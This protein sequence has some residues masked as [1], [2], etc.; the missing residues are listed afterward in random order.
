MP[1]VYMDE[2]V[3]VQTV[4]A[5]GIGLEPP[6]PVEEVDKISA[7][8]KEMYEVQGKANVLPNPQGGTNGEVMQVNN[9]TWDKGEAPS[10][11]VGRETFT[12][13]ASPVFDSDTGILEEYNLDM[14][15][16]DIFAAVDDGKFPQCTVLGKDPY[17]SS[18]EYALPTLIRFSVSPTTGLVDE[19]NIYPVVEDFDLVRGSSALKGFQLKRYDLSIGLLGDES[20]LVLPFSDD[21]SYVNGPNYQVPMVRGSSDCMTMSSVNSAFQIS[22]MM[23]TTLLDVIA[24]AAVAGSITVSSIV[25]ATD[26][27][28]FV[29]SS[30]LLVEDA[31]SMLRYGRNSVIIFEVAGYGEFV[32]E[33]SSVYDGVSFDGVS[34]PRRSITMPLNFDDG[35]VFSEMYSGYLTLGVSYLDDEAI[36]A[37]VVI[38]L[39]KHEITPNT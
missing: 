2:P 38:H 34:T 35:G 4:G 9:D 29:Q 15:V 20:T 11:V 6:V 36:A 27:P 19:M 33:L 12:F 10:P 14:E 16:A 5:G 22:D 32:T 3:R 30:H 31:V 18:V 26:D 39:E 13:L 24:A 8:G 21:R 1:N 37:G 17:A 7:S 23:S 28:D 25:T